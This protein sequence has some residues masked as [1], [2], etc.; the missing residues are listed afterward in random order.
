M[1]PSR[2]HLLAR[3]HPCPFLRPAS[4][5]LGAA[6]PTSP[7]Q[8]GVRLLQSPLSSSSVAGG[9]GT[10]W[11]EGTGRVPVAAPRSPSAPGPRGKESK[12]GASRLPAPRS[13]S[14][15]P[16]G[17]QRPGCPPSPYKRALTPGRWIPAVA[18][19]RTT[20]SPLR[21]S[22]RVGSAAAGAN[23]EAWAM[24]SA[25]MFVF[26]SCT[27]QSVLVF[28]VFGAL[29]MKMQFTS[30]SP[31]HPYPHPHVSPIA[32][33]TSPPGEHFFL[34][35]KMI[36]SCLSSTKLE[37]RGV[38]GERGP[39]AAQARGC[40]GLGGSDSGAVSPCGHP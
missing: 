23:P 40:G 21:G 13:I 18:A 4:V 14:G 39:R 3:E 9:A 19:P 30:L 31:C 7:L 15:A 26:T 1:A 33:P 35:T 8:E 12:Q 28:S 11:P 32:V 20:R 29:G 10:W 17:S 36:F 24:K 22:W 2:C 6:V 27:F 37:L 38:P 16:E 25:K 5:P 34:L